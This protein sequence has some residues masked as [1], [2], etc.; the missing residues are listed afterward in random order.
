M[1]RYYD[2]ARLDREAV[3]VAGSQLSV[4]LSCVG[5]KD[6][7]TD[8]VSLL[9]QSGPD[10]VFYLS[11]GGTLLLNRRY[12]LMVQREATARVNPG[13]FSLFTGRADGPKEWRYPPLIV[14]E[15]FE[16]ME[17]YGNGLLLYPQ[18]EAFQPVIDA[19]YAAAGRPCG[20][21]LPLELLPLANGKLHV[22]EGK[23][24]LF[25]DEVFWVMSARGEIN[26]L[27][28]F[29]AT[30]DLDQLSM[31]DGEGSRD[32]FALDLEQGCYA[33]LS[34]ADPHRQWRDAA[35]LPMSENLMALRDQLVA[36]SQ[37]W[38]T[39]TP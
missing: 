23:V 5:D 35:A 12:I 34:S 32:I 36:V 8:D 15:L 2:I 20:K 3:Q 11:G 31:R 4:D 13:Q 1:P 25:Q 16:E 27:Y 30:L 33:R 6:H 29:I 24:N 37:L 39:D 17:I 28:V 9:A 26:L 7:I 22:R 18:C 14:R 38:K 19:V 10:S 21:A